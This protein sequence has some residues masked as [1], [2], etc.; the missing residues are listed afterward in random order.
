VEPGLELLYS[1]RRVISFTI[2]TILITKLYYLHE[3]DASIL[4]QEIFLFQFFSKVCLSCNQSI[5][6]FFAVSIQ[7]KGAV[8][9]TPNLGGKGTF[10]AIDLKCSGSWFTTH[11]MVQEK[12][13]TVELDGE[14]HIVMIYLAASGLRQFALTLG[15]FHCIIK[16]SH[17][18]GCKYLK[19]VYSLFIYH[20]SY[21]IRKLHT[22]VFCTEISQFY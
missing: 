9:N 15:K 2:Y 11:D 18:S 3:Y 1:T 8:S 12:T 13:L 22:S 10:R 5:L 4:W 16:V 19:H 14:F 6:F 21:K 7:A 20:F 17:I